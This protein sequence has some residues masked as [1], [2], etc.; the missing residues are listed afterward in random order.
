MLTK[1][2][3]ILVAGMSFVLIGCFQNVALDTKTPKITKEELLEK[4]NEP[5]V[6]VIDVRIG[7]EWKKSNWKIKGAMRE[8]P[9]MLKSWVEKYS[10]DKTLVF[11]CS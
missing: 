1:R 5:E 7:N 4:L 2:F 11:Y 10:K 6:V 9:E 3:S 8:D